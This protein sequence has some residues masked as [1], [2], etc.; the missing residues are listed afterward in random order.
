MEQHAIHNVEL[1][2]MPIEAVA[3]LGRH[4]DL[5]FCTGVLHHL[6][7]PAAGL[8]A[9]RTVLKQDGSLFF[10]LYGKYG[11]DGVYYLQELFRRIG[12]TSA[13][14]G[15]RQLEAMAGLIDSLPLTHP[16]MA[17][18]QY[19]GNFLASREE[20]VDLFLHPQDR[21]YSVP[22]IYELLDECDLTL[23][24][25]ILRAHY[26]PRC[27]DLAKSAF[28]PHIMALPE[29][30]QFAVVELFRAAATMH[31]GIACPKAR[32]P[33]SY[34]IDLGCTDWKKLVPVRNPGL[35]F[36]SR[37][38]PENGVR[39]VYWQ[40][41]MF[42]DI[43][44]CLNPAEAVLLNLVDGER[45]VGEIGRRAAEAGSVGL[46]EDELREFFR[47]MYDYDYLWFHG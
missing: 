23:Q 1:R 46:P 5:V 37:Q 27:S 11:R 15:P 24:K 40:G 42:P 2:E 7:D 9:L 18:K 17:K 41:H 34:V 12:L 3:G 10:M 47:K 4:F 14:A 32:A 21:A 20:M 28:Y 19:F 45:S 29:N 16:L 35:Q 39:W 8:H 13:S 25:M 38:L 6:P 26:S 36:S 22:G 30:E 33:E 44:V 31:F 43:R